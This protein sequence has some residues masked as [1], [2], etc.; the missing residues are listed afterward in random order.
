MYLRSEIIVVL[1][2]DVDRIG[3]S[4]IVFGHVVLIM[5]VHRHIF[6]DKDDESD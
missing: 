2:I 5:R 3:R 4:W 6:K 1:L